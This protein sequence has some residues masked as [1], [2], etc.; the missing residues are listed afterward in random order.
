MSGPRV[1]AA[2]LR[3]LFSGSR[4]ESQMQEELSFHVDMQTED[5]L[6]MGMNLSEARY[7]AMRKFGAMESVKEEYRENR[8]FAMIET[9]IRNIRYASRALRR[10]PGF[11]AVAVLTLALGIGANTAMFSVVHAVLLRP[12]PY[13]DP[14]SLIRIWNTYP[15][16]VA[17]PQLAISPG[18]FYDF[19][20]Q[21]R[22]FSGMAAWVDLPQGFNLTG[23]G[24]PERLEAR[25][26]TSGLFSLLGIRP[27]VGRTFMPAEDK[28]GAARSVLI[29]HRLWQKHFGATSSIAGR[30][31]RLDGIGYTL[32]GV[33]PASFQLAPAADLWLPVGQYGD[34]LT[35]HVHHPFTTVARLKPGV[36]ISEAQAELE[37]LD[38]YEETAFPDTHK[39]WKVVAGA[40]EDPSARKLR[41]VLL[42]L[43]GA[44]ALV[45]LIACANVV[46]LIL[47]RNAARQKEIAVRIALGATL[48]GLLLQ[49]LI[50]SLMLTGLGAAFG[51][52]IAFAGMRVLD[53]TLPG[54]LSAVGAAT[55]NLQV[56]GFTIA[57]ALIAGIGCGLIPA[58]Q[59]L[60]RDFH[61]ALKAGGR[62]SDAPVR[63][64]IRD[65][66]VVAETSLAIVLTLGATLFIRSFYNAI[67]VDPGFQPDRV[68]SLKINE[69]A[70]PLSELAKLSADQ[71]TEL[72]RRQSRRFE[73]I[74]DRI[75]ALP[76]VRA[77]GGI[78]ILPL[79]TEIRSA[80][81]F[82]VEGWPALDAGA[83]PVAETRSVS[84]GYFAAMK[85]PLKRG[86]W[87]EQADYGGNNIL[88]NEEFARRFWPYADPIGKRINLC[89]L[90]PTPCWSPIVGVV[91]D[92]HQYGLDATTRSLDLYFP[93]GTTPYMV[94]R[95]DADPA[96]LAHAAVAAIHNQ[97]PDLP[98][99]EV[100]GLSQLLSDSLVPRRFS[101]YALG[102]FACLALS[103][104]ATGIY[105]VMNYLVSMR[106]RE[107]GIRTALG[108]QP[109][110]VWRLVMFSGM[111]LALAG[112]AIGLAG[113]LAMTKLITGLVYEVKPNDPFTMAVPAALLTTTVLIACHIP[114]RRA[115]R[116]DPALV[117]REE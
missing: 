69:P 76:G 107:I 34:D 21:A 60:S 57:T 83:R 80:S 70:I 88:V 9:L 75:R 82:L 73:E 1:L 98:V 89:S 104:A 86:R 71:Q 22:S 41:P 100:M 65:A 45:L 8:T 102:A 27:V 92:I 40:M 3:G 53:S 106:R 55:L 24:E 30:V 39:G 16:L 29:S 115:T 117:L 48:R 101:A 116:S 62:T 46:N 31:L 112:M 2:R 105:G 44:V 59:T 51:W 12:L 23:Q 38:R 11:A 49:L 14:G 25:Y 66:L 58:A 61:T 56:L 67:Q 36:T 6:R 108:A 63:R 37:V 77:V 18:D 28:P 99:T 4:L 15:K 94:I 114:A 85:I 5:N 35:G 74:A 43:F 20:K 90:F 68:L 96:A 50:E 26:A 93:G 54:N 33:L 47:A 78:S 72:T 103:L 19:E 84:L 17:A 113:A 42:V 10:N 111:K 97:D 81:R 110:Q 95:T 52:L 64:G 79:G 87:L 32:A 13:S 109:D 7:A 91:G